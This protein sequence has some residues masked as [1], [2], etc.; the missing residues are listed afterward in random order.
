MILSD[1]TEAD[2]EALSLA[3][4]GTHLERP[5]S[6][7]ARHL[8]PCAAGDRVALAAR[9]PSGAVGYGTLDWRS[10][11]PPFRDAGIPEIRDLNVAPHARRQGVA[12]RLLDAF[13]ARARERSQTVGIGFGLYQDYGAAQ[14]LYV[15]RGYVPD[16]NGAYRGTEPVQAGE[17]VVLNDE[18]VLFLVKELA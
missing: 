1:L 7:I 5:A 14:R 3:F 12:S 2:C 6:Q 11:H 18:F 4:R 13:E 16:G 17:R 10:D 9:G 8:D 15:A